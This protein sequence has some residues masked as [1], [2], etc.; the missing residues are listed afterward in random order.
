VEP[1]SRNRPFQEADALGL[2]L[3][4]LGPAPERIVLAAEEVGIPTPGLDPWRDFLP[5]FIPHRFIQLARKSADF[6]R[7]F[8]LFNGASDVLPFLSGETVRGASLFPGG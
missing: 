6:E 3:S 8:F 5:L 1:A 2:R 7:T 4:I